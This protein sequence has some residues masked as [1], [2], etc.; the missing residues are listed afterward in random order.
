MAVYVDS[1]RWK[2]RGMIMCHM[3]ADTEIELH[4]MAALIGCKREWYQWHASTPHYDL[5]LFRRQEAIKAGA[6]EI[7]R[8]QTVALIRRIRTGQA[9]FFAVSDEGLKIE[10]SLSVD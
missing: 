3:L 6:I 9:R 2:F 5:P 8:K 7:D 1:G 4:A 10:N